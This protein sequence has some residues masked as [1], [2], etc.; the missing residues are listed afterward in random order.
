LQ[1]ESIRQHTFYERQCLV[2]LPFGLAQDDE[3]ICIPAVT[4]T[5]PL[6][7]TTG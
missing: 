4:N 1:A 6:G 2:R 5:L 7:I 3:V